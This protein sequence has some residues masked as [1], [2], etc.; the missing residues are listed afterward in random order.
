MRLLFLFLLLITLVATGCTEE[1]EAYQKMYEDLSPEEQELFKQ[2]VKQELEELSGQK[3]YN[4]SISDLP[5]DIQEEIARHRPPPPDQ[6]IPGR[7]VKF[8][9][10]EFGELEI[11]QDREGEYFGDPK[12][13]IFPRLDCALE[14]ENTLNY[15]IFR[16]ELYRNGVKYA[17]E[18]FTTT[19]R[20]GRE[21][22]KLVF[23]P[24]Y[25]PDV[26]QV[27]GFKLFRKTLGDEGWK[28]LEDDREG[29]NAEWVEIGSGEKTVVVHEDV[30]VFVEGDLAIEPNLMS[31]SGYSFD[32]F[33]GDKWEYFDTRLIINPEYK[34]TVTTIGA[35]E[36]DTSMQVDGQIIR[37]KVDD[38]Y[39][40]YYDSKFEDGPLL[41]GDN[42][43]QIEDQAQNQDR[44]I[45]QGIAQRTVDCHND[46][47]AD[48]QEIGQYDVLFETTIK[49]DN[50]VP[51][52]V[53]V[54]CFVTYVAVAWVDPPDSWIS[55]QLER[56][57]Q[58]SI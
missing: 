25:E 58:L 11:M 54:R 52:V 49:G 36:N 56:I 40:S 8:R 2:K 18:N 30:I 35:P 6:T 37:I 42:V 39:H 51:V 57:E 45:A 14:I 34:T 16:A 47:C 41:F 24:L 44:I 28:T 31:S 53:S 1:D 38:Y 21:D 26:E 9:G 7:V 4:G 29:K 3:T 12:D 15:T 20:T 17:E 46:R 10:Y 22:L 55:C 32:F 19:Y 33:G 27:M 43:F 50:V 13:V 23:E 48:K 5:A